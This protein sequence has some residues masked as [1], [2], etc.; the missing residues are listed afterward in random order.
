MVEL[1]VVNV[2]SAGGGT[3]IHH[4]III[5]LCPV[6]LCTILRVAM[7]HYQNAPSTGWSMV[8]QMWRL[9]APHHWRQRWHQCPSIRLISDISHAQ[10]AAATMDTPMHAPLLRTAVVVTNTFG[11]GA[12]ELLGLLKV[13]GHRSLSQ[14]TWRT[15]QSA[16][17][18]VG[19]LKPR[20][21]E[22]RV[23][24]ISVDTEER[25]RAHLLLLTSLLYLLKL[26]NSSRITVTVVVQWRFY[27]V[28]F[29]HKR[30]VDKISFEVSFR[31]LQPADYVFLARLFDL[32][33]DRN[34]EQDDN[35]ATGHHDDGD[36]SVI[37]TVQDAGFPLLWMSGQYE[38]EWQKVQS[39]PCAVNSCWGLLLSVRVPLQWFSSHGYTQFWMPL[40]TSVWLMHMLLWQ[41]KVSPSHGAEKQKASVMQ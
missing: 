9:L 39:Q 34:D 40:Q 11:G 17:L 25:K 10:V 24:V 23:E 22:G 21:E 38:T 16:E 18:I 35:Q 37:Q 7:L 36:V 27:S 28:L 31:W 13:L 26:E 4:Q 3:I 2:V 41:K 15:T 32:D 8:W 14:V 33:D 5:L 1:L 19:R 20:V 29:S 12:A 30:F 6:P